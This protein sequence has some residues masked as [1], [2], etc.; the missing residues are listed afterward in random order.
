M[1]PLVCK[2]LDTIIC[3]STEEIQGIR[4]HDNCWLMASITL[5]EMQLTCSADFKP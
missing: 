5:A 3:N 2:H 1:L 4:L